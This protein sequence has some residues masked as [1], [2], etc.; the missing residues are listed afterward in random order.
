M[1]DHH[2]CP[3]STPSTSGSEH[4][5]EEN[6]LVHIPIGVPSTFLRIAVPV[7]SS[8]QPVDITF[9]SSSLP[10]F[11]K[12]T[13]FLNAFQER[14]A[15]IGHVYLQSPW[16]IRADCSSTGSTSDFALPGFLTPASSKYLQMCAWIIC[17]S[18]DMNGKCICG[19]DLLS[20]RASNDYISGKSELGQLV[21]LSRLTLFV[22]WLLP[23]LL[24]S[25][26]INFLDTSLADVVYA[27]IRV[28][29]IR[30]PFTSSNGTR[31]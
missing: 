27:I 23:F 9:C 17:S 14:I 8:F 6:D 5:Q 15:S 13:V 7:R 25:S 24:K 28:L 20:R 18:S 12:G 21:L 19:A 29:V 4:C 26:F 31:Q 11:K 3:F 1:F 16:P 22:F 10:Y 2:R 30:N